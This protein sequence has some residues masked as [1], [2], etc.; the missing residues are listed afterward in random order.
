MHEI[1]GNLI[2]RRG[3][4]PTFVVRS[5]VALRILT[6]FIRTQF[7]AE[8]GLG[9]Q[10]SGQVT[11]TLNMS[12]IFS[13]NTNQRS[14]QSQYLISSSGFD[15]EAGHQNQIPKVTIVIYDAYLISQATAHDEHAITSTDNSSA[16][17]AYI[18][19]PSNGYPG[20]RSRVVIGEFIDLVSTCIVLVGSSRTWQWLR[21]ISYGLL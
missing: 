5:R 13:I 4:G 15:S 7:P 2:Y 17:D 21:R 18:S 3:T 11:E 16:R 14:A 9:T 20:L 1:Q 19:L 8:S 10:S 12:I 6:R